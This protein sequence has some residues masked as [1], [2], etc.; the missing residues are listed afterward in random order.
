MKSS[1]SKT[2]QIR[3]TSA[4]ELPKENMRSSNKS[5][6]SN[7]SNKKDISKRSKR[8]KLRN[9]KAGVEVRVQSSS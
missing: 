1:F 6:R 4:N 3:K 5:I 7:K 2:A 8:T 9:Q